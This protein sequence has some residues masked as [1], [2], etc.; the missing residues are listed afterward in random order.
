MKETYNK[1][2]LF[3]RTGSFWLLHAEKSEQEKVINLIDLS[4]QNKMTHSLE[5]TAKAFGPLEQQSV[6]DVVYQFNGE[7][8]FKTY[9]VIGDDPVD[10][11]SVEQ[12]T[13]DTYDRYYVLPFDPKDYVPYTM[14]SKE[15]DLCLN[16][17]F[18]LSNGYLWFNKDPRILFNLN[19]IL[20]RTGPLNAVSAYSYVIRSDTAY[21][22]T[23]L[24]VDFFRNK[25]ELRGLEKATHV[26]AGVPIFRKA[27]RIIQKHPYKDGQL[28][29][30]DNQ[31]VVKVPFYH[32]E[33][34]V[35]DYVTDNQL[36]EQSIIRFYFPDC[37]NPRWYRQ[38]NWDCG[39]SLE[40]MT[41]YQGLIVPDLDTFAFTQGEDPGSVNGSKTHA[42]VMLYGWFEEQEQYWADVRATETRTGRYLN[43]YIGLGNEESPNYNEM[44]EVTCAGMLPDISSLPN[45]KL[46]NPLDLYFEMILKDKTFVVEIDERHVSNKQEIVDFV[47]EYTPP[48]I[49]PIVRI[50]KN[51]EIVIDEVVE[52]YLQLHL[53]KDYKGRPFIGD[54]N[55]IQ[56]PNDDVECPD[57]C[58]NPEEPEPE[59][60]LEVIGI[61]VSI[62]QNFAEVEAVNP[63]GTVRYQWYLVDYDCLGNVVTTRLPYDTP[64][65][66]VLQDGTYYVRILDD[67]LRSAQTPDIFISPDTSVLTLEDFAPPFIQP[68]KSNTWTI[69]VSGGGL[70]TGEAPEYQWYAGPKPIS[71]S[72]DDINDAIANSTKLLNI[73]ESG[74]NL[75]NSVVSG[76]R[77]ETV[78]V[79]LQQMEFTGLA[80]VTLLGSGESDNYIGPESVP[81]GL[82][83]ATN[84]G[85]YTG[86]GGPVL[87]AGQ[88]G[89]D[90]ATFFSKGGSIPAGTSGFIFGYTVETVGIWCLVTNKCGF[91]F[92]GTDVLLSLP[93]ELN[94]VYPE[95]S[96]VSNLSVREVGPEATFTN[97][98]LSI[99][100][101]DA[102][103]AF[104]N[105]N[106]AIREVQT[107]TMFQEEEGNEYL[108]P[109]PTP[110]RELELIGGAV[111]VS[112]DGFELTLGDSI[113]L[114]WAYAA[115]IDGDFDNVTPH[116]AAWYVY[117]GNTPEFYN[118]SGWEPRL[119]FIGQ[120]RSSYF[121][122]PDYDTL[123]AGTYYYVVTVINLYNNES[124]PSNEIMLTLVP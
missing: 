10:A 118:E 77:E 33:L 1:F 96:F 109:Q 94:E 54:T 122:D 83:T 105:E 41:K 67:C 59:E 40:L 9:S 31:E 115:S 13:V 17:D 29:I 112:T 91:L 107:E 113:Q 56:K 68:G 3:N 82:F 121:D 15:G 23:D 25:L 32:K 64:L 26:L 65:I 37:E 97:T 55:W 42:R 72:E 70:G 34:S 87:T 60:P 85:N 44:L 120:T 62:C 58:V 61:N 106:I 66:E 8:V 48:G 116:I 4:R 11:A 5:S 46:L 93:P 20:I 63:V 102:Q 119:N 30:T 124:L 110:P 108:G 80:V 104:Q 6:K 78:L 19:T 24:I 51:D 22:N 38:T 16:V 101:V 49:F 45:T 35:R 53:L 117:R 43:D 103:V 98:T 7:D 114:D 88:I 69:D 36:I 71:N 21:F 52:D 50:R 99:R 12:S 111:E 28:Y 76:A 92:D 90:E 95:L 27:G 81:A 74:A 14:F 39:L 84:V 79:N 89:T 2:E 47:R 100:E 86:I 75:T 18:Y 73:G 57:D 123:P